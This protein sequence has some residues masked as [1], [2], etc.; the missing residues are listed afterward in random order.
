MDDFSVDP[1]TRSGD[2]FHHVGA[3]RDETPHGCYGGVV[4]LG[5]MVM[6]EEGEEEEVFY[7]VLCRRCH[8]ES[9]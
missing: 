3:Q 2:P 5:E 8:G 1:T 9:R 7:P 6:T 4:Y